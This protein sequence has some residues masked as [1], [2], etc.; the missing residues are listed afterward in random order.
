MIMMPGS[1]KQHDKVEETVFGKQTTHFLTWR[2]G[3]FAMNKFK[4]F[5]ISYTDCKPA[6]IADS[7]SRENVMDAAVLLKKKDFSDLDIASQPINLNGDP[8]RA[9]FYDDPKGNS[10]VSV[11]MCI[12]GNRLY[13][14][15]V[16]FKDNYSTS[17]EM[18][19]F[20]DSFQVLRP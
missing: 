3:A 7:M 10:M 18:S 11:K 17:Q 20:F 19:E 6:M 15:T 14:L 4:L 13:F 12:S 2:P 5:E 8:G 9:F 1:A 16:V